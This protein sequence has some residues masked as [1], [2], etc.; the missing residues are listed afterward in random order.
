MNVS[1]F[2]GIGQVGGKGGGMLIRE[3]MSKD[4]GS[5]GGEKRYGT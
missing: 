4:V 5:F 2:R 1:G 3:T